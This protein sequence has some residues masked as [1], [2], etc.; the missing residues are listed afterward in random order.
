MSNTKLTT[1]ESISI[2]LT[3][4]VAHTLVLLPRNLL[5]STKS[6]TIIN[7]I[8]IGIIV[9]SL[10]VFI[11]KLFKKFPGCDIID[12]C[13]YLGGSIFK[14]IIGIVF[15]FYFIFSASILLRNFC[16]CLKVVYYPTTNILFI[17]LAFV[18][19]VCFASNCRFES[20][21]KVN[22]IILPIVLFTVVFI[23]VGNLDNLEIH[24]LFPIL[25]DGLF[26]TF[27][28]GLGNLGAFGGICMIY[29]LPPYLKEPEKLKKISIISIGI[30]IVYLILCVSI[31]LFMFSFLMNIDEIMPL[32]TAARYIDFGTFFQRLESFLLLFWMMEI[33][34]YVTICM[35]ISIMIF[36]KIANLSSLKTLIIPFGF[37][38][39]SISLL[40]QNS[41][42]SRFLENTIYKYL[43]I[44]V[45]FVL[46]ISILILSNIKKNKF[47]GNISNEKNF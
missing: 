10:D 42:I 24:N 9:I 20:I 35:M 23:F 19:T 45:V 13:E 1:A 16:E 4:L 17:I 32:Y 25:G 37:L 34:C 22:L 15:I 12:I 28:T 40:P 38:I 30:T 2:V 41:A 18:T 31:L 14:K 21:A 8:Y 47:K 3:I 6:A 46:S 7:L 27:I 11:V 33:A 26:N 36:K 43:I 39:F 29:F 5:V 44:A